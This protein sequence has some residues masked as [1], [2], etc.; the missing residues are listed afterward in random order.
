M[1]PSSKGD[2][3][4]KVKL[5]TF[6]VLAFGIS[7][8]AYYFNKLVETGEV[9]EIFLKYTVKF[10]PSIAGLIVVHRFYGIAGLKSLLQKAT[11][12]KIPAHYYIWGLL[13][14]LAAALVAVGFLSFATSVEIT[15]RGL[16]Y[17]LEAYLMLLLRFTFIGGGLGE[18][19]GWRGFMLPFLMDKMNPLKAAILVGVAHGLW[20]L[21]AYGLATI[22]LTPMSIA[23]SVVMSYLYLKTR[24]NLMLMILMHAA[25]NTSVSFVGKVFPD[26]NGNL[27]IVITTMLV[28][29]VVATILGYKLKN[30]TL[31]YEKNNN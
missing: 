17:I 6:L 10:G 30:T 23:M 31:S 11:A 1:N 5:I 4:T 15:D 2:L 16:L 14:P 25:V 19:L 7:T 27:N 28:W 20:H 26:L 29:L 8:G 21:P 3:G 24:G 22:A 13:F 12:V 18:E 9:T